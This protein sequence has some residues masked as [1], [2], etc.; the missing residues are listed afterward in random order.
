MADLQSSLER[1]HH[2]DVEALAASIRRLGFSCTRCGECC[3]GET[4]DPHTATVFPEEVRTIQRVT[5]APWRD[6]ARPMPYGLDEEGEGETFEWA[7]Q[8]D[9]CGDCRFLDDHADGTTS[10]R[11]YDDRPRICETYPFQVD[12]A[13]V[14]TPEGDAV[15]EDGLVRAYE[16]EGLGREIDEEDAIELARS[17]KRRT[18]AEIEE[19]IAL[20]DA[21]EAQPD[22]AGP[23]VHDSEGAK[24]PDGTRY[25]SE[26]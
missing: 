20:L 25:P 7:L 4:A 1:A 5:E 13:G 6:V 3:R 2:L 10:C 19:A 12:L 24:T 9:A 14:A 16:C 11:I 17:L 8:V 15:D 18:I 23:I 22:R 26:Q 21:F